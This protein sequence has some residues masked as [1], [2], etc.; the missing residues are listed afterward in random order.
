[1]TSRKPR[2]KWVDLS[3]LGLGSQGVSAGAMSYFM[4]RN[5]AARIKVVPALSTKHRELRTQTRG[6]NRVVPHLRLGIM[7][8]T[9]CLFIVI[10]VAINLSL[11][12]GTPGLQGI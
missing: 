12:A 3:E 8:A 4:P 10:G 6:Q 9:T 2:R 5:G 1:V 7:G 11:K